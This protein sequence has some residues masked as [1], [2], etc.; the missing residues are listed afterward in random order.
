MVVEVA[1]GAPQPFLK[2]PPQ[3][4]CAHSPAEAAATVLN[5]DHVIIHKECAL[6]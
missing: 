4:T 1:A 5:P 2:T 6:G 3:E